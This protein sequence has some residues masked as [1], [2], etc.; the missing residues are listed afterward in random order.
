MRA[1][2]VVGCVAIAS[3]IAS[4]YASNSI[5]NI[6][7]LLAIG[8]LLVAGLIGSRKWFISLGAIALYVGIMYILMRHRD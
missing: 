2:N 4:F 7:G 3:F 1:A 8:L 5:S 6:L